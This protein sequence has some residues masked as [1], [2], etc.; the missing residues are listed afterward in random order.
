VLIPLLGPAA[1]AKRQAQD[2]FLNHFRLVAPIVMFA[3]IVFMMRVRSAAIAEGRL[4]DKAGT[5]PSRR[6]RRSP[7][8]VP[9]RDGVP[10]KLAALHGHLLTFVVAGI[11]APL[12]DFVFQ[13]T[14]DMYSQDKRAYA[15]FFAIYSFSLQVFLFGASLLLSGASSSA[16]ACRTASF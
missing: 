1:T 5:S 14:I 3:G 12:G 2:A 16:S 7:T 10:A 11:V 9:R 6:R 13:A 4:R 15:T 8:D